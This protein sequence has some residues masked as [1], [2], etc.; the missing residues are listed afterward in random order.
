MIE[1]NN[2]EWKWRSVEKETQVVAEETQEIFEIVDEM[3]EF[4]GGI[5]AMTKYIDEHLNYPTVA[6]EKGI[7]GRVLVT[8]VINEDGSVSDAEVKQGLDCD[9]D[10]EA[11]RIVQSMPKW[12][13]GRMGG[14]NVRV[15]YVIPVVFRL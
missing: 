1:R 2:I 15:R 8:C 14:K 10:K 7:Q 3:P 13:P 6:R 12:K 5:G 4:S 11:I 9:L